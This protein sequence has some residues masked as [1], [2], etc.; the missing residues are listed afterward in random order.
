LRM[1]GGMRTTTGL[2]GLLLESDPK[3]VMEL[4]KFALTMGTLLVGCSSREAMYA[5]LRKNGADFVLVEYS[6]PSPETLELISCVVRYHVAVPVLAILPEGAGDALKEEVIRAGVWDFFVRP[7]GIKEYQMRMRNALRM[8]MAPETAASELAG[9]ESEIRDAIGEIL[10]RE[11]ETLYVLGKAA[12]YKDEDT[13]SHIIRVASYAKLIAG[14]LGENETGQDVVYH[15]SALHDIGKI[16][17][18]D[19]ILLK[20]ARLS[21]DEFTIMRM[22][23]IN[24]HGIL[25]HSASSYLLTGA[26]IALTHHERYD[27]AGYPMKLSG[28]EIPLDGRIVCVADVF[29]ALTTKRPYKDP[30]PL[31]RAFNLLK[32]ERRRQ[33]D[34]E[35]VDAFLANSLRVE[36]IYDDYVDR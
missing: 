17:I 10:L 3:R 29:D 26:M 23:T 12:E 24:G 27:G 4:R 33:F 30:W 15:A 2:K 25:E 14:M 31:E 22:H 8:R 35:L 28:D 9:R 20:P 1:Q 34:P 18:P 13:G 36:K 11:Y 19:S 6:G 32:E 5:D 16:G 7:V 21:D